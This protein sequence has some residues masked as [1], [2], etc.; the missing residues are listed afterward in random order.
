MRISNSI[1]QPRSESFRINFKSSQP[2]QQRSKGFRRSIFPGAYG[3]RREGRPDLGSTEATSHPTGRR[4][5]P[6]AKIR[7]SS[8]GLL[9]G[10]E[11]ANDL[12]AMN[13]RQLVMNRS[14]KLTKEHQI[15]CLTSTRDASTKG[16]PNLWKHIEVEESK[17]KKERVASGMISAAE[18]APSSKRSEIL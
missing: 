5:S 1:A 8:G 7:D 14:P 11:K 18:A 13:Q 3:I 16:H 4:S 2:P 12:A 17:Q 15:A 9:W 6:I 10:Q